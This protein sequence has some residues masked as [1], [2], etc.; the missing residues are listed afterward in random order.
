MDTIQAFNDVQDA[1][2]PQADGLYGQQYLDNIL[3][4]QVGSGTSVFR[5]DESGLWLGA[6]KF[7]D[8]PFKI[9]MQ[10]NIYVETG[11]GTIVID[12]INN[13]IIINDGTNDRILIGYHA[14]GF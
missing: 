3:S 11:S 13:R 9:D 10:G 12:G 8:A 5:A 14:N 4:M 1:G 7:A 2:M 6:N